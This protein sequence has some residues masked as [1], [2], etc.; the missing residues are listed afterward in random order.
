[1]KVDISKKILLWDDGAMSINTDGELIFT[2]E[3]KTLYCLWGI[4][5]WKTR[6]YVDGTEKEL[7]NKKYN[8]ETGGCS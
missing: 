8:T 4:P 6:K 5:I 1:M 3:I 2:L 7:L